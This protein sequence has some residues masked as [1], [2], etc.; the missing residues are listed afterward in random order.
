MDDAR[1]KRIESHRAS[2]VQDS[3]GKLHTNIQLINLLDGK[4]K[5]N[6]LVSVVPKLTETVS[7]FRDVPHLFADLSHLQD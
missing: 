1:R 2:V 6:K 4:T 5:K 3:D 7:S